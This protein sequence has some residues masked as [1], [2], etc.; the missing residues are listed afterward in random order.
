MFGLEFIFV[1]L[2]IYLSIDDLYTKCCGSG[3]E[4]VRSWTTFC[5]FQLARNLEV[6]WNNIKLARERGIAENAVN[7]L[8]SWDPADL[9]ETGLTLF[10]KEHLRYSFARE[11]KEW[12]CNGVE[13]SIPLV[14][15]TRPSSLKC[16]IGTYCL[17]SISRERIRGI[18]TRAVS[19]AAFLDIICDETK[20]TFWLSMNKAGGIGSVTISDLILFRLLCHFIFDRHNSGELHSPTK[21]RLCDHMVNIRIGEDNLDMLFGDRPGAVE[22]VNNHLC[23]KVKADLNFF[24]ITAEESFLCLDLDEPFM[25]M[26]VLAFRGVGPNA[27]RRAYTNTK[28][29]HKPA[30]NP[31]LFPYYDVDTPEVHHLNALVEGAEY[32]TL[33][34]ALKY[35][36]K[37]GILTESLTTK[38]LGLRVQ[39]N[40]NRATYQ[41]SDEATRKELADSNIVLL[42]SAG[43]T[44]KSG[45]L[46]K[47]QKKTKRK[48]QK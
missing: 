20:D 23:K 42:Q 6:I 5:C 22:F 30:A 15:F 38:L 14:W 29:D 11:F 12:H 37:H 39:F 10:S 46:M 47:M 18:P 25:K 2:F 48:R 4:H 9:G 35:A 3:S 19:R 8:S 13:N 32:T 36:C 24:D 17:Y 31:V 28:D 26:I 16:S 21:N 41:C 33:C 43:F 40:K 44:K 34:G 45:A 7:Q 27:L 1:F